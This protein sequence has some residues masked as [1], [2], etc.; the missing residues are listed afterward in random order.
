M[1]ALALVA[2]LAPVA[3]ACSGDH[4]M[5]GDD[6]PVNCAAITDDDEFVIGLSKPG[7]AGILTFTIMS[8]DP[9]PPIRGDNA[10]VVEITAAGAPVTNA[11]IAV[12]P[13]MPA[14]GHGA[15]K[16]AVVQP[17]PDPGQ[18]ELSPI[19]LWMPGVWETTIDVTSAS[20][21]DQVTFKFCIPS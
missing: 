21:N 18:Y 15:G 2:L 9:A 19:N 11:S 8:G 10:W 16:P 12:T 1:R 3:T 13:F 7:E 20:G 6:E 17:M 4:S 14:H 5:N